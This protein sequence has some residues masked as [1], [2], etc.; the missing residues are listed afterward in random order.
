MAI[1]ASSF[2]AASPNGPATR[3][4]LVLLLAFL[5]VGLAL[6]VRPSEVS[7][8]PSNVQLITSNFTVWNNSVQITFDDSTD[9]TAGLIG[10]GGSY[11]VQGTRYTYTPGVFA[12]TGARL[13]S[14]CNTR[15]I[16]TTALSF[17]SG[18]SQRIGIKIAFHGWSYSRLRTVSLTTPAVYSNSPTFPTRPR[19][20]SSSVSGSIVSVNWDS[21]AHTGADLDWWI[22]ASTSSSPSTIFGSQMVAENSPSTRTGTFDLSSYDLTFGEPIYLWVAVTSGS[23]Y[24]SQ[25]GYLYWSYAYTA[26]IDTLEECTEEDVLDLGYLTGYDH[27]I[28]ESFLN[29]PCEVGGK[30]SQAFKL[31]LASA[32]DID[33]TFTPATDYGAG[34]G[35]YEVAIRR[36]AVD[37]VLLA[38]GSGEGS[39]ETDTFNIAS[40]LAYYVT[41]SRSGVIGR[42]DWVLSLAYGFIEPPTPTPAPTVTP[43]AQPNVDFRLSP[44]PGGQPYAQGEVYRFSFEGDA[45]RLPVEIRA[46]NSSALA[47]SGSASFSCSGNPESDDVLTLRSLSDDV[48]MRICEGNA[49][50]SIEVLGDNDELLAVYTIFIA[51]GVAPTPGSQP[52]PLEWGEDVS[53]RDLIGLTIVIASVCRG[54]GSGCDAPLIK[55]AFVF[56]VAVA[57][58]SIPLLGGRRRDSALTSGVAL[59][60]FIFVMMLGW[61]VAGFPLWILAVVIL[62]VFALGALSFVRKMGEMRA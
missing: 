13:S 35:S 61:L 11:Q 62:V 22:L 25:A 27:S 56:I 7:A 52:V 41:V 45:A 59:G 16:T 51:G 42:D 10:C 8:S 19:I 46:G 28:Q 58:A 34:A 47:L 6:S 23:P 57:V 53:G 30:T 50:S 38:S 3:R 36:N 60:L 32:R 12:T 15:D 1:I 43:R 29:A 17:G 49:N 4:L 48:H 33:S 20:T 39:F 37:G 21:P 44:N 2:A 9:Y 26:D 55:N 5:L 24:S 18:G 31:R 14:D 40:N 54:V